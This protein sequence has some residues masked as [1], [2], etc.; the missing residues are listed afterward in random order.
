MR[1]SSGMAE[2]NKTAFINKPQA[3]WHFFNINVLSILSPLPE[4][5]QFN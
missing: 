1:I 5:F 3:T 4:M 2:P